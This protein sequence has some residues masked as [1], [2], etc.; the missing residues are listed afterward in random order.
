MPGT[1]KNEVIL[2]AVTGAKLQES[3]LNGWCMIIQVGNE[4]LL[5]VSGRRV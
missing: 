3:S 2:L 5:A 1:V 4:G